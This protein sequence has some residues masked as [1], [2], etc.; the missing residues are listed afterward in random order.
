MRNVA[1]TSCRENK[2]HNLFSVTFFFSEN[3]A[4]YEMWKNIV[5]SGNSKMT[6]GAREFHAGYLRL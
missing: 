3:L 5:K 1:D 4:V 6:I 2:A